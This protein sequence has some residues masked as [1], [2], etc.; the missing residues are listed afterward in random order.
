MN[1]AKQSDG[2]TRR[3]L[4]RSWKH[5]AGSRL[6]RCETWR[7]RAST[8][9]VP[10]PSRIP[11]SAWTLGSTGAIDVLFSRSVWPNPPNAT[12][13]CV[14]FSNNYHESGLYHLA[15]WPTRYRKCPR[16]CPSQ[17]A[18]HGLD[19]CEDSDNDHKIADPTD[20]EPFPSNVLRIEPYWPC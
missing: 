8:E 9:S 14:S 7:K 4:R 12:F 13:S 18:I 11:P 1:F 5:L 16:D 17:V 15:N 10:V 19:S 3:E 20:V 2:A 6:K